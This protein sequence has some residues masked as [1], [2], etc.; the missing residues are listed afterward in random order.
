METLRK[1]WQKIK[2]EPFIATTGAAAFVHS[3]WS[4]SVTFSGTAPAISD[5]LSVVQWCFFVVPA[6]LIAFAVDVGQIATS[7]EIRNGNRAKTKYLT[8]FVLAAATYYLQWLYLA[9]H[10]PKLPLGEGIRADWIGVVTVIKDAAIW[11]LPALLPLAT[12]LYTFSH[13]EDHEKVTQHEKKSVV[14]NAPVLTEPT[15]IMLTEP[16]GKAP[17]PAQTKAGLA[18]VIGATQLQ[19]NGHNGNGHSNGNGTNH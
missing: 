14:M 15:P 17:K 19:G 3:T 1:L 12:V 6:A 5:W 16:E 2:E 10:I 9:H 18:P 13:S 7:A 8:F 4:L 11:V